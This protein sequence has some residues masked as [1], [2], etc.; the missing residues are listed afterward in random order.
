MPG[1][2][3]PGKVTDDLVDFS[4][5][6]PTIS[7]MTGARMP[8]GEVLDG[9]SFAPQLRGGKGTPR[10]WTYCYYEPVPGLT[11]P[12]SFFMPLFKMAISG[13]YA[14][15]LL[16]FYLIVHDEIWKTE[17]AKFNL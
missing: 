11:S 13:K 15:T 4:D 5:M 8:A 1:T 7:G 12:G 14:I 10:E 3:P 6:M 16:K 2:V 9:V 17:L